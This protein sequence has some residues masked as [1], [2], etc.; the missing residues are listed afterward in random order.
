AP[1]H[2]GA[3]ATVGAGSVINIDVPAGALAIE[4]TRQR[5]VEGWGAR[6]A[7]RP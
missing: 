6:R 7:Q 1:L 3:G 2:I 4:R 5:T